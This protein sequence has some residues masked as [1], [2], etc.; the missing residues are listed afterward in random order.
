MA[1]HDV[2]DGTFEYVSYNDLTT[3]NN[4]LQHLHITLL[5]NRQAQMHYAVSFYPWHHRFGTGTR[6]RQSFLECNLLLA[7][8]NIEQ[9]GNSGACSI[10]CGLGESMLSF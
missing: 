6:F 7:N 1:S 10:E 3:C 9:W 4:I 5:S 8:P 2:A